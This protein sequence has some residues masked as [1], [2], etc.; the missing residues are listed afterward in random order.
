MSAAP[1]PPDCQLTRVR[2]RPVGLAASSR[3]HAIDALPAR[4]G[5][6]LTTS[7]GHPD[8]R[9]AND[10]PRRPPSPP[11]TVQTDTTAQCVCLVTVNGPLDAPGGA[12]LMAA[13][14]LAMARAYVLVLDLRQLTHCDTAGAHAV[15]EVDALARAQHRLL[16]VRP[17]GDIVHRAF[18]ESGVTEKLRF[19]GP[20]ISTAP[21]Q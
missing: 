17:A 10:T 4:P 21:P 6:R 8:V 9:D 11:F 12:Q 18:E 20:G 13:A 1:R 2:T 16:V 15:L 5:E 3:P 7:N 19:V 14:R